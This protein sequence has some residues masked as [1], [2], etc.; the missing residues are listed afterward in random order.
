MPKSE[1]KPSVAWPKNAPS[2]ESRQ[3]GSTRRRVP[4]RSDEGARAAVYIC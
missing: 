3:T 1:L 4:F 2:K